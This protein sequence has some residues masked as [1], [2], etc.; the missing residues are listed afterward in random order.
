MRRGRRFD[1]SEMSGT[2]IL[3]PFGSGWPESAL[4]HEFPL[5]R[6]RPGVSRKPIAAYRKEHLLSQQPHI[7]GI[8]PVLVGPVHWRR[9]VV[10]RFL[11]RVNETLSS[12]SM[13]GS[14]VTSPPQAP[15]FAIT[16]MQGLSRR[17]CAMDRRYC[18]SPGLQHQAARRV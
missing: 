8:V 6:L 9:A 15:S 7:V 2:H 3:K 18:P 16:V 10:H 14:H 5:P 17:L 4:G 13:R 12:R 11:R 1:G